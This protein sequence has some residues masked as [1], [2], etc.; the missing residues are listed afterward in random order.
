VAN[1]KHTK[2]ELAAL[3]EKQHA[4]REANTQYDNPNQIMTLAQTAARHQVSLATL[5][6]RIKDDKRLRTIQLSARRKGI[7]VRDYLEW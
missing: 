6:R 1:R 3:R 4:R 2:K 7:R 5:T